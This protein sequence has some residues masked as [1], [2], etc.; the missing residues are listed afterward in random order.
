MSDLRLQPGHGNFSRVLAQREL[1]CTGFHSIV[2]LRGS[3]VQINVL[4]V[5]GLNTSLFQGQRYGPSWL[6]RRFAHAYPMKSF[7]SRT[8][9]GDLSIDVSTASLRMIVIFENEHP[10]A[11]SHDETVPVCREGSRRTLRS[12]IP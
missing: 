10:R 5:L 4:N 2:H 7:T 8:I 9:S 6:V 12:V 3:A 11:L 1:Y